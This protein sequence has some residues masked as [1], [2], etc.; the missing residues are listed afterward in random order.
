MISGGRLRWNA[1]LLK[2]ATTVDA[3]GRRTNSFTDSGN[4]RCDLRQGTPT[5]Q[6]Y[7]DGVAVTAS[8][9]L[10]VRW[11]DVAR[12]DITALDRV[13]VRGKTLRI[14]GIQNLDERDRLAVIDCTEVA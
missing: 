3:L 10:R 11:P 12:V 5:E 8:Y 14:N 1:T 9:E 2:A 4:F 13:T 7:A 6:T